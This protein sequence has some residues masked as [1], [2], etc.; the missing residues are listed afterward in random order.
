M[1]HPS[2]LYS[3]PRVRVLAIGEVARLENAR[4]TTVASVDGDLWVTQLGDEMDFVI[5]AGQSLVLG[6]DTPTL[7]SALGGP[8]TLRLLP[9][10]A[11]ART[12]E[13]GTR[14]WLP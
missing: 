4:G 7:I 3:A 12:R 2:A 11:D 6:L 13:E 1:A 5:S 10:V 14:Q 8:A 9:L